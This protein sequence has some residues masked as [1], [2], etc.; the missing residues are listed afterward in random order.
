MAAT[1][2]KRLATEFSKLTESDLPGITARPRDPANLYV[3][4]VT[5]AGP[6][7]TPYEDGVFTATVTF[8]SSYPLDPPKVVFSPP[9]LH[10]NMY[11]SGGPKAGEVCISILHAGRDAFGYERADERWS[12][13]QS[14]QTVLLSIQSML[15]DANIESPADVDAAVMMKKRP[16]EYKRKIREQVERSLGLRK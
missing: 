6:S 8:P 15:G 2:T 11:P 1:A 5:I 16:E 13:V 10:P 12:P 3:W 7:G 14:L 9:I 4:D